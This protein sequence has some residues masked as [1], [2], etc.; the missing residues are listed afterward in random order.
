MSLKCNVF[1]STKMPKAQIFIYESYK[2]M[3]RYIHLLLI[4]V[5]TVISTWLILKVQNANSL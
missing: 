5:I 3:L 1:Y 2:L 4:T